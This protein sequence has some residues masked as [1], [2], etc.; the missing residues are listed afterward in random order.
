M[1]QQNLKDFVVTYVL[2][3]VLMFGLVTFTIYF[4]GNNN[5]AAITSEY[6]DI[7]NVTSQDLTVRLVETNAAAEE[8]SNSTRSTN[9]EA[10]FLGSRD[11]VASAYKMAGSSKYLW[12]SSKPLTSVVLG[13]NATIILLIFSGIIVFVFVFRI[14]RFIR[15]GE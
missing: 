6:G 5:P 11:Q 14:F 15:I 2:L 4:I 8:V 13:E 10:S 12:E 1:A 7:L 3:G 9:P